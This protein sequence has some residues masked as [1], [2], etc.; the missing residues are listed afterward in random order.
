ML[1]GAMP[2]PEPEPGPRREVVCLHAAEMLPDLPS[3]VAE[4]VRHLNRLMHKGE[5]EE[6]VA[7]FAETCS[8]KLRL[9]EERDELMKRVAALEAVSPG[10]ATAS[11]ELDSTGGGGGMVDGSGIIPLMLG[12][13][14]VQKRRQTRVAELTEEFEKQR[15]QDERFAYWIVVISLVLSSCTSWLITEEP[16]AGLY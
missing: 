6:L 16:S 10:L 3:E 15:I 7:L 12:K 13:D 2:E 14:L 5:T 1:P 4:H 8:E 11:K 9:Q